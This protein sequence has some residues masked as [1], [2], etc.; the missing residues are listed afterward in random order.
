[1][2]E[3]A[4]RPVR[5]AVEQVGKEGVYH[6]FEPHDSFNRAYHWEGSTVSKTLDGTPRPLVRV[7]VSRINEALG[8]KR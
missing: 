2:P 6:R 4:G 7:P 3:G 1:M 5:W 8:V